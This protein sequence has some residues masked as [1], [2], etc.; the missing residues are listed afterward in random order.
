MANALVISR[1]HLP[2]SERAGRAA[3][4]V[5]M[6]TDHQRYSIQN[7]AA[8]IAAFA[9]ERDL[10]IVRTYMDEG[11]SG[12]RIKGRLGLI[13]LIEDVRSGRADFE[14]ILVY[15]VSRWGRFQDVDE[16]AHYEFICK[17]NGIKVAYC[18]EQFG[19]DGTL[20][21]SIVKNIKRLMAAEFSRELSVKVQ[22]GKCRVARLGFHPGGS[23][24]FGLRR[25]LIDE[26]RRSKGELKRG[27]LKALQ[28]DRVLLALGSQEE[29][30]IVRWIFSEFVDKKK[31]D[32]AIARQ[33]NQ[34]EIINQYRRPWT[35]DMIHRI[36]R[37][38]NYVGNIIYNRTSC[39]L[40]QRRVNNHPD[41]WVRSGVV[42]DPIIDRAHFD[43]AQKIMNNRYI[44][45]SEDEM[46]L[47]LRLLLKRK[48][49]LTISI[50]KNA[51]GLPSISAYI[52]H[53]GSIRRAF[54]L[55]GYRCPRD[56]DWLDSREH[57]SDVVASHAKQVAAAL[58]RTR[59]P[60][61]ID[62]G[63]ASVTVKGEIRVHFQVARQMKKT[64]PHFAAA[65]RAYH[66]KG[67]TG[68][69]V[70]LRLD[71]ANRAIADYLV[72]AVPKSAR[73]YFHFSARGDQYGAVQTKTLQG[74]VAVIM[75]RLKKFAE[76]TK[77][78]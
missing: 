10:T 59:L 42:V 77:R 15:D 6:S 62:E 69:L 43:R 21:S 37:N 51:A 22:A 17:Q 46:L 3:Q 29:V 74:L 47:R 58:T 9:L 78:K 8:A 67:R 38:E 60:T 52:K 18:A 31:S 39:R 13:E 41:D 40:G 34:A 33:L 54:T 68:F 19:N 27:E 28:T 2:A 25:E 5:R 50:M 56:C 66:R 1:G 64:Q 12:L 72:L 75:D 70:L 30:S 45:I 11:R 71:S 57:W 53:F 48:G 26:H 49:K 55:I 20:L 61:K 4:Y 14:Q 44:R 36:L 76:A 16:S 65:W 32:I 24:T 35:A 7:Q 23:L 73:W 63:G